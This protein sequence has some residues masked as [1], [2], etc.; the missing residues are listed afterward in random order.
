MSGRITLFS[1]LI[2]NCFLFHVFQESY[3]ADNAANPDKPLH[4]WR[5]GQGPLALDQYT[6]LSAH[7][8]RVKDLHIPDYANGYD[9]FIGVG[10]ASAPGYYG[11]CLDLSRLGLHNNYLAESDSGMPYYVNFGIWPLGN[12]NVYQG[13][14][15][16]WFMLQNKD[17][18]RLIDV[19][20]GL[21][22]ALIGLSADQMAVKWS[23]LKDKIASG[24]VVFPKSLELNKWHY[25]TQTWSAGEFCIYLDGRMVFS[26]NMEGC[27]GIVRG[28]V[29]KTPFV[30]GSDKMAERR[31]PLLIDELAVSGVVRYTDNFEPRW[32]Q[33]KRP[34]WAFEGMKKELPRYPVR[35]IEPV[36]A[37]QISMSHAAKESELLYKLL[38]GLDVVFDK[39]DGFIKEVNFGKAVVKDE[40][41]GLLLWE[42]LDRTP[43]F[44]EVTAD[45]W[46]I[47]EKEVSF[48]QKYAKDL[49]LLNTLS[50]EDGKIKWKVV[51]TNL[52]AAEKW[53][54]LLFS[55][56]LPLPGIE[57][58][59]DGTST[60]TD[61]RLP[62]RRDDIVYALPYGAVSAAG[63]YV[64]LATDPH[65]WLSSLINEW[66]PLDTGGVLRQGFRYVLH[67]NDS[68]EFNFIIQEGKS[69]FGCRNALAAYYE[70]YPDLYAMRRD[71]PVHFNLP[72]GFATVDWSWQ[73][74]LW[75]TSDTA[76]RSYCGHG[77]LF[78]PD[79]GFKGDYYGQQEFYNNPKYY[80]RDEYKD[81][82]RIAESLFKK[83]LDYFR[84]CSKEY[85]ALPYQNFYTR[86]AQHWCPQWPNPIMCEELYPE[87]L[88]KEGDR[89]QNGQYYSR[90][91]AYCINNYNTPIGKNVMWQVDKLVEQKGKSNVGFIN[92]LGYNNAVRH[93]DPIAMKSK[94][95]AFAQDKGAYLLDAFGFAQMFEHI[96]SK[97][98]TDSIRLGTCSDGG[99]TNYLIAALVD[100][101]AVE[102]ERAHDGYSQDGRWEMGRILNGEKPYET[103]SSKVRYKDIAALQLA[104]FDKLSEMELRDYYRYYYDQY[105]LNCLKYG[106][107]LGNNYAETGILRYYET[108]PFQVECQ[109]AGYKI[110]PAAWVKPDLF[111]VRYGSGSNTLIAVGNHKPIELETDVEIHNP[112]LGGELYLF[113]DYYGS[114]CR[115]EISNEKT[116]LKQIGVGK[117]YIRGFKVLAAITG[118]PPTTV[119]TLSQG[120]GI[121]VVN[122]FIFESTRG[123]SFTLSP[124]V[125]RDYH[126]DRVTVDGTE[127]PSNPIKL[128]LAKGKCRIEIRLR[129]SVLTFSTESWSKVNLLDNRNNQVLYQ[130]IIDKRATSFDAGT[131]KW[132]DTF[133]GAYDYEDN[134][135]GNL[136]AKGIGSDMSAE[137]IWKICLGYGN[138]EHVKTALVTLDIK[139]R[140]ILIDGPDELERRRAMAIFMRLVDRKYPCI[141]SY[142]PPQELIPYD[143]LNKM[144]TKLR[145]IFERYKFHQKPLLTEEYESLY[146][147]GNLDFQG[148]YKIKTSP[149]IFEPA[150]WE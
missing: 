68:Q 31:M 89:L 84:K 42:G 79:Y 82:K 132:L 108:R 120:D 46:K 65:T 24:T 97:K 11:N 43:L 32:H 52:S 57:E 55:L 96:K 14:L 111:I 59:F 17:M 40:A 48:T 3:A 36:L 135:K 95:R 49:I 44:R 28:R 124:K 115:Q 126:I 58:Y 18:G 54:E 67:A 93:T 9:K 39:K 19:F 127:I 78:Q 41:G 77:W 4:P 140:A 5:E 26:F 123:C 141:G 119:E 87:G 35:E 90:Q 22:P 98:H 53:V 64:G 34:D 143:R 38:P 74:Q 12:F 8:D 131:A 66:F 81:A 102:C 1:F 110:V 133:V 134:I 116:I 117:R 100:K 27:H 21:H 101:I 125:P 23:C 75:Y 122:N 148:R 56:P 29:D 112:S 92:D 15:E 144:E 137:D 20:N 37:G 10:Y 149:Y 104:D 107:M 2:I 121:E 106:V 71:I 130:M 91:S 147:N 83:S 47:T 105:F 94:G 113:G 86:P 85:Y 142:L 50:K 73:T 13:T 76:R 118:E 146:D 51:I 45:G 136:K 6:L 60:H 128:N 25:Y 114:T 99:Y 150:Q 62:R 138:K 109:L 69:P 33:G 63:R 61:N 129:N 145:G 30:I 103:L 139:N 80:S 7:F 70:T 16:F 72:I 88:D